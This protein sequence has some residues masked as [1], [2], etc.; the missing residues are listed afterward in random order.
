MSG[1]L[2]SQVAAELART[3]TMSRTVGVF[4]EPDGNRAIVDVNGSEIS[5]PMSGVM[6]HPD[7]PVWVESQNGRLVCAGSSYQFAPYGTVVT[8][9]PELVTVNVDDGPTLAFPYRAGLTLTSGQRVEINPVTYVVQGVLSSVPSGGGAGG[10]GGAPGPF[11]NLLVQ[12]LDSGTS[13]GGGY[14]Q[15]AVNSDSAAG[16]A[17]FYGSRL[18]DAL[19]GV[20]TFTRIEVFLPL[21]YNRFSSPVIRLHSAAGKPGSG[22]PA[23]GAS[24]TVGSPSGWVAIPNAW[25]VTMRD[26]NSGVGFGPVVG[27]MASWRGKASD[28]MSGAIRFAGVR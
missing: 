19:K 2:A 12:A 18:R 4:R 28:A 25:G 5:I 27:V 1:D 3:P 13:N 26:G 23:F 7:T 17:W 14:W 22:L 6:P 11:T 21:I 16:G 8:S 9:T 10:G 20:T 24:Y 15:S